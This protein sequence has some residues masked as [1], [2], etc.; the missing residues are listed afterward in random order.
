MKKF[1]TLIFF[2]ALSSQIIFAFSGLGSGT[3]GDPYQVTTAAQLA[4]VRYS[5][6]AYYKQ[7]NDIDL[8]SYSNWTAI[9]ATVTTGFTG[10]YDGNSYKITGLKIISTTALYNGL[11]GVIGDGTTWGL[12]TVKNLGIDGANITVTHHY[13]GILVGYNYGG[14]IQNCY[15]TGTISSSANTV[16]GFAGSTKGTINSCYSTATVNGSTSVTQNAG[17]FAGSQLAFTGQTPTIQNCYATGP[18]RGQ[19]YVG[20]FIGFRNNNSNVINSY[21]VGG[22]S[23]TTIGG[24]AGTTGTGSTANCFWDTNTSGLSTSPG[25]E[26]G[27]TTT[28]MQTASTFSSASWSA[29][30]WILKDGSYPK[31]AW[32]LPSV[33]AISPT[34]GTTGT[35]VLITGTNFTGA[36]AVNFGSTAA[37]SYT[38]NSSTSITATAP[39]GSGTVDVIVTTSDGT[40]ATSSNDKF[41][42]VAAPTV[43]SL[44]PTSGPTTG[45]TSVSITGTNFTG[46]TAVKFG[47][48]N[49]TSYTVNSATQITATLPANSAG[50]VDI[51][52]TTI[53][54]ASAT[55]SSDQ[56][57]YV[58][59]PSISSISP[60]SGPTS[61][62]TSVT[63]TGT[64]LSGTTAVKFGSTNATGFTVNSATQITATSPANSAGTVDITVT[65]I[66]GTSATSSSDQFTYVAAPTVTSL[67][68]T[69][70]PTTGGTSVSIT[71]T[72]FTGATAVKFGSTN[73]T[74][75]TVNSSTSITATSP[76][77]SA[78]AADITVTTTGGTSATGSSD[79]FTYVAAPTVTSLSPTSGP[80]T[81]GT[82]VSITGT[83][84]TGATAVK[85]GS[86][87]AT[88]FTVNSSTSITAT[89][90][91]GSA[92][93][94][95][96]TVTTT[97]GTSATGSSDQFTYVAAPTVT[98]LS[99]TSGPTTG[100][101]SV[102]ITGT[103]FTGATAVKFGSTN[104]T[105][106]TVNS[107]T[108]ITATSPA[109]SAGAADITVTTTGG[110]SAT[111]GSD[112]FTY[113][114]APTVTSISPPSGPLAGGRSV[115]IT[116]TNLSGATAVKFGTSTASIT[117]NTSTQI[118][119]TSPAGAAGTVDITVTTAG[120]TSAT[121][122][123]DQFTYSTTT[124]IDDAKLD[125]VTIYPNPVDDR[126]Y[127][128][129]VDEG[130]I[131]VYDMGGCKVI[132]AILANAQ[133]VDV[134]GLAKGVYTVR[135]TTPNGRVEKKLVKK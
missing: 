118:V 135:I 66:G 73:A 89:S 98:S 42:Y 103:N 131:A 47:S 48:T 82:S 123:S 52:V 116:G 93:A 113:V 92:G 31:L 22:V 132:S 110:T 94:A 33:T 8:S 96:I 76:A 11:F 81:G 115:T 16:G 101:T 77:G 79:Q 120:G 17:G 2:L 39:S 28:E 121:S 104:A 85:F 24:F 13:S 108:S 90:P 53:G 126:L 26:I 36:T 45:G 75:F 5:L 14:V 32:Q 95:D 6:A 21:S 10:T 133:A 111:G 130:E 125:G 34:S 69:S 46:A 65:T 72:N 56:F 30:D 44:S 3:S 60:T 119:A 64:N 27:K 40:S 80:T 100:G 50:T 38:V 23:G 1:F 114:V 74:G 62:T 88:G 134:S 78:G 128:K 61:G 87:N 67:S 99:P 20:G 106:F 37:T 57:T 70:G 124:G 7:M 29:S 97:G 9:G 25:S 63:I 43:T 58:A 41:T 51:T 105:G 117:S 86:T 84:F 127:I 91:A 59:A 55:S 35:S 122:N 109:G 83:N 107:S 4:E 129:G 102:S 19:T 12:G 71:G 54:G 112:Q 49:A 18:V 15:T 68:P